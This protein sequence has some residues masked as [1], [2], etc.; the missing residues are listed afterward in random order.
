MEIVSY[1]CD[2]TSYIAGE[3]IDQVISVLQ[4]AASL[5]KWFSNES[6]S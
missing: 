3:N 6:E 2:N 5:F 4:N 1:A